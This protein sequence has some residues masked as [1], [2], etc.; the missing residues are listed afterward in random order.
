MTDFRKT[1]A[2]P[3][4]FPGEFRIEAEPADA[5]SPSELNYITTLNHTVA[6]IADAE[7]V[8]V[9]A[10]YPGKLLAGRRLARTSAIAALGVDADAFIAG[11]NPNGDVQRVDAIGTNYAVKI[12]KFGA[13]LAAIP[14]FVG[15]LDIVT[16]P[17]YTL[18]TPQQ[19]FLDSISA[20]LREM[21][22]DEE[23]EPGSQFS[24]NVKLAR[25]KQRVDL[26][27]RLIREIDVFAAGEQLA[28][29]AIINVILLRG[30]YQ[31]LR[32]RLTRRL[33]NVEFTKGGG[34][35]NVTG[36][37]SAGVPAGY[38]GPP[39]TLEI[40]LESD[41][42]PP[43]DKASAEKL[44]LY[45]KINKTNTVIR[46]VCD[47]LQERVSQKS[48]LAL[49]FERTSPESDD[50]VRKVHLEFLEKLHSVAVIGLELN[51][52]DVAQSTLTELRNEF[53]ALEAGRTKSAHS[54]GLALVAFLGS[55]V[56]IAIYVGIALSACAPRYELSGR[57]AVRTQELP[58]RCQRRGDR[59][60]GIL[61]LPAGAVYL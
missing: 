33:F 31:A 21:Q 18:T 25:A 57:M 10:N 2:D 49:F 29:A 44:D 45:A 14:R 27:E 6:A 13:R 54:N 7:I 59:H 39:A 3:P 58:A 55:A 53:F 34:T 8:D 16:V 19:E 9:A 61:H 51:F 20:A 12:P 50:R 24:V 41:L 1:A 30:R 22:A 46:T 15:D 28:E 38:D 5:V 52:V 60:L 40:R 17:G 11:N 48:G 42:P 47:R 4:R 23:M 32:D 36:V 43:E 26:A 35:G 37:S 56:L